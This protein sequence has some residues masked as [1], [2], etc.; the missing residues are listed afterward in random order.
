[1]YA[2]EHTNRILHLSDSLNGNL[3]WGLQN[4]PDL[5]YIL[6]YFSCFLVHAQIP[7]QAQT[8]RVQLH[9]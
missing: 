5:C 1:M 6:I 9:Q 4:L 8:L 2:S 3:V 7:F